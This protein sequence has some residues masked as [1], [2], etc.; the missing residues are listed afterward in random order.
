MKISV[1]VAKTKNSIIGYRGNMPWSL[2]NDL[3]HFARVTKGHPVIMGRCTWNS[4]PAPLKGRTNIIV[5]RNPES[6]TSQKVVSLKNYMVRQ[7]P[8]ENTP[9]LVI[10]D[11]EL[12]IERAAKINE[13]EIFIIGGGQIYAA[14]LPFINKAY[15]T[16]IDHVY[17]V[18]ENEIADYTYFPI[19][20]EARC[21]KEI[22]RTKNPADELHAYPYDFVT[23]EK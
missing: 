23:Y 9:V 20:V 7:E 2:P 18:N 11:L 5:T 8:D 21:W 1:I 13:E 22:D 3:R 17:P 14:A 15:V 10:N 6:L 12:A 16:E 4:L 19:D